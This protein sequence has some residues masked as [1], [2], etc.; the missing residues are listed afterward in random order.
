MAGYG[1]P[2]HCVREMRDNG[3]GAE[4]THVAV[5]HDPGETDPDNGALVLESAD[6]DRLAR[7]VACVNFLA[8]VPDRVL[9]GEGVD[10][11]LVRLILAVLKNPTD[12]D[13]RGA[14]AGRLVGPVPVIVEA[15]S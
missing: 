3:P 12:G 2:W 8:G 15:G 9:A 10:G 13:A 4:F 5:D 14:L 11:E 6:P 7:A 1:E